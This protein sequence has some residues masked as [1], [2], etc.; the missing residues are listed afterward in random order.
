MHVD[1]DDPRGPTLVERAETLRD[2]CRTA[3]RGNRRQTDDAD[4]QDAARAL[5]IATATSDPFEPDTYRALERACAEG[6]APRHRD[7]SL[8]AQ[9]ACNPSGI[10]HTLVDACTAC[11]D[12]GLDPAT[13]PAVRLIMIQITWLIDCRPKIGQ[14]D[15][16]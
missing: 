9:G 16:A 4:V 2:A 1:T 10:A 11:T 15:A 14:T 12:E 7:A 6:T 5:A 13:D 3:I 8:I